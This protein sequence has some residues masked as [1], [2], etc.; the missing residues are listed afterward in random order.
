MT[1]PFAPARL[2]FGGDYNPEQWPRDVWDEDMALMRRA[3]VNTVTIGVFSWA[4]LEPREG[5][6]EPGWLDDVVAL[7]DAHEIGF[8]LATPTASPPPWFTKAHPDALPV[9]P[10]GTQLWHGSRD[11][12]AI[13]APAYREAARRVARFLAERYGSHPRLRGW[14]V[15][16]EYGTVDHGP[17]A[18]A[19]FR[20]WLQ[21]RYGSLA[22]L[23][24]AWYTAF[25]SQRYDDW[26]EIVPPRATQYLHNPAQVVDF[27][28]F[29]SAEMLAAYAEQRDEIRATGSSAPVT[30][31]FMLPTWN[32]LDQWEWS[33]ELDLVSVDHYLDTPGPDGEAHV[34]YGADLTRSWGEGP[35]LLMEQSAA[36]IRDGRRQAFKDPDRMI[37]NS[38][39]YVARG[40]QG[41]LFFQWRASAGGS[42]TW[43]SAMVPHSGPESRTYAGVVELGTLLDRLH[44]VAAPPAEGP[45]VAADVA[46]LWDAAGWWSLETPH[47]PNDDLDYATEA[48]A[49]HRALW[50][51][52][53]AVDFVRSGAD[54]ARYRVLFVP[55]LMALD[56]ATVAWLTRYVED[57]GY[58]VVGRFTGVADEHERVVPGGYP[59]RLRDLLGVRVTE[60]LPLAPGDTQELSDGSVVGQWTERMEAP[61]AK[62]VAH[63]TE[64]PLAGSPAV[65][66]HAVGDGAAVYV[67][68]GLVQESWD[69][70]VATVLAER[71]V[72]AV[73]P[74][75]VGTGLEAVRR[76]GAEATY[77]FLLHHG[78]RPLRV[79][80]AGHD[81]V[82]DGPAEDG[83]VIAPGSY[84]VVREAPGATWSVTPA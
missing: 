69:A 36:G 53:V 19:A 78:D 14:H 47:L 30:T 84:A 52:G 68:A 54:V 71:D 9:R 15:H 23:N 2:L 72:R 28:R 1:A 58:L 49:T 45:V 7:L 35:W 27:K 51:A 38:L 80:G 31:N 8:F 83:I 17:H 44:E 40:S 42:E 24:D 6:F 74:E 67:S 75:A 46:V 5:E 82:S 64:G 20:R 55:T 34:A 61:G 29:C 70:F 26:D 57:G 22:V 50:R 66:R 73:V 43:H 10:D 39:G 65:T 3:G 62:V 59:G 16:N 56:A 21:A 37:R 13:S 77:L 25:W 11:T 76:R 48:R 79:A 81:L 41:A 32:H 4:A 60:H 12:Y 18:A 63:Y 33:D